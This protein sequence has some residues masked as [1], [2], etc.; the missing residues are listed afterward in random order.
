MPSENRSQDMTKSPAEAG[1]KSS[2]QD[3]HF[4]QLK[5]VAGYCTGANSVMFVMR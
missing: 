2:I 4:H 3:P 5:L 1:Y